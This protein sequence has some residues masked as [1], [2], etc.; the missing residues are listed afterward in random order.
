MV[1]RSDDAVVMTSG[2]E[3]LLYGDEWSVEILLE[4]EGFTGGREE[5][6]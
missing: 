4:V 3:G 5:E 1:G 2:Y 6:C